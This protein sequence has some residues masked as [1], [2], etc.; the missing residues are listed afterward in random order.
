MVSRFGLRARMAASYMLVSAA[1]VLV[2]EVVLLTL[3]APAIRS[4]S[5]TVDEANDRAAQAT[6]NEALA[7]TEAAT[8]ED[9]TTLSEAVTDLAAERPGTTDAALL[10][11]AADRAFGTLRLVTLIRTGEFGKGATEVLTGRDRHVVA[12]SAEEDVRTGSVL[13]AGAAAAAENWV[14]SPV[15]VNGFRD[16]PDRQIGLLHVR[17]TGEALDRV[18]G[19]ATD[20]TASGAG[21]DPP[22][23]DKGRA[24][25]APTGQVPADKGPAGKSPPDTTAKEPPA[26]DASGIDVTRALV[27]PG[28]VVLAL[29]VPVGVLFGL[30]S[31]GRLIRR[32]QRLAEGTAT[33]AEGDLAARIPVSGD[34]EVGRLEQGFNTMAERLE[35]AVAAERDVAGSQARLAERTRIAR[36]LHDSVSQQLFSLN[37]LAGGMRRALPAGSEL[38]RQAESMERTVDRT[39]REMRAMLLELRPV[40][41]EDAGLVAALD[42]LCLAYETRLGIR[43]S[44]AV[45][46]VRMDPPVE[47]AVLRVVQEALTN[48]AR[49]GGADEI[50]LSVAEV[51]GHV[52][53]A[54]SDRGRG[55]DPAHV[56][57][58]HGLG[59]DL[60]RERV[61]ELGGSVDVV[62]APARGTTVRVRIPAGLS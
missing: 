24:E 42:E 48:A 39:M 12:T 11:A 25:G 16:A 43:V 58:R 41:L 50:E 53:V 61:T 27:L 17:F 20:V 6:R 28:V 37:L 9:A 7:K 32:V 54:I 31:T 60:M 8:K 18:S 1:A 36:E 26:A 40:G 45:D 13:P 19:K 2:V 59:L 4:A 51:Q 3:V 34:D 46:D 15:T 44:A 22:V 52:V 57:Q 35:A 56:G 5:D 33:M 62:S 21:Q 55:F 30:L 14:S 10:A 49:H 38:H 29:L 23:Q 47:H